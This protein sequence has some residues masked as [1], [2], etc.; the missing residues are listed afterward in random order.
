MSA[1]SRQPDS[2]SSGL[3][4]PVRVRTVA[5]APDCRSS[6]GLRTDRLGR[7]FGQLFDLAAATGR[8]EGRPEVP[9]DRL[10]RDHAL[11]HVLARRE[12]EHDVEEGVLDDRAEAAGAGLA[13]QG[14]VAD[15]P[16]GVLGED[17]L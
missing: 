4:P 6:G 3:P 14:L 17:Q 8:D 15:L 5:I 13:L 11:V 1:I 2:V 16:E 12:L 9:L 10:L 7:L